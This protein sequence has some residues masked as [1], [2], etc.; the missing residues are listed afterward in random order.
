V[1]CREAWSAI[2]SSTL[3]ARMPPSPPPGRPTF[4][5]SDRPLARL[6]A[7]PLQRFLHVEAS[8]GIVL[9]A[10]TVVALV[11]ANSPW[12][13]GYD[14]VFH[15]EIALEVGR[16]RW[17]EDLAHWVND[18]LMA[19]FFL[20]VG[21]EIKREWVAGELRDR[22]AAALPAVAAIGG[23]VVP[24]N[25]FLA[26]NAGGSG[27]DGWGI[28]MATDIAFALGVVAVLGSRVPSPLKVF[29]LTLAIVDDI[30]AIVVIAVFYSDSV[31]LRW[32]AAA[33]LVVVA[34]LV[35]RRLRVVKPVVYVGLGLALW[36]FVYSSGVHATIAGVVMGLLVPAVPFQD[37]LETEAIVDTLEDRPELAVEDVRSVSF[38]IRSSVPLTDRM[39]DLLHP[40]TSYVVVPLFALANAGVEIRG[41]AITAGRPV[42]VG[43]VLGLVV[44]KV[45]G[46]TGAS[47]IATRLGLARL[48]DG[49]TWPQMAGLAAIAGIGFTVSLFVAGLA[50][51]SAALVADAKVGV[52]LASVLAAVIGSVVLVGAGRRR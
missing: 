5:A 29:L 43:V 25:L 47:W 41:E 26:V 34:V 49:V 1:V 16:H 21:L 14:A 12:R 33:L 2:E 27:V 22:R 39:L 7:R 42:V 48:P 8:G 40:W 19:V 4:I 35:L 46:I 52:L 18:A 45:V 23:M 9:L 50:F 24:A 10:A 20:V 3:G 17:S 6:V 11:W 36:A 37:R 32:L 13:A 51:P 38:L 15:T 28:P 44:G 30:G 31:E